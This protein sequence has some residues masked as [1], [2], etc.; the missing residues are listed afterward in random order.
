MAWQAGKIRRKRETRKT[1][2]SKPEELA[3]RRVRRKRISPSSGHST[4][5][6]RVNVS[7]IFP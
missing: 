2:R 3:K 5:Y 6:E 1:S 4:K 7:K